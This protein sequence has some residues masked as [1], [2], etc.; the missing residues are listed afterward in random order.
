MAPG[1]ATAA[2]H[3]EMA[4]SPESLIAQAD[5]SHDVAHHSIEPFSVSVVHVELQCGNQW[6]PH[7]IRMP[8]RRQSPPVDETW[9]FQSDLQSVLYGPSSTTGALYQARCACLSVWETEWHTGVTL[10]A[11]ARS[12][13]SERPARK[14]GLSRCG[15]GILSWW[16][17]RNGT[18][19]LPLCTLA[20]ACSPFSLET[21]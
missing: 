2:P 18:D 1:T 15:D 12:W 14:E 9:V 3:D 7:V 10:C 13:S 5:G 11:R 8:D 4:V 16:R 20:S 19:S 21:Q 6:P 17:R